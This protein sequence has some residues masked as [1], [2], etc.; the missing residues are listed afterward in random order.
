MNQRKSS[1]NPGSVKP[2]QRV[3]IKLDKLRDYFGV[4]LD[5]ETKDQ[6]AL[7]V[8]YKVLN[9]LMLGIVCL[10]VVALVAIFRRCD[11]N[12]REG[13]GGAASHRWYSDIPDPVKRKERGVYT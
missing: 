12:S 5:S 13:V 8:I 2:P 6:Y 11:G 4:Q 7:R 1:D 3:W 10:T 9:V